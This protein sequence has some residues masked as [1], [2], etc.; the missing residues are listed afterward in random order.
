M[1]SREI[2][3]VEG[4]TAPPLVSTLKDR[5]G[6]KDV[7]GATV[8]LKIKHSDG[9]FVSLPCEVLAPGS[10]GRVQHVWDPDALPADGRYQAEYHV[11]FADLTEQTFP[12]RKPNTLVIRRRLTA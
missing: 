7:T 1:A 2:T 8:V 6:P 3:F 9:T 11:T 5:N 12:S 10:G 4:D